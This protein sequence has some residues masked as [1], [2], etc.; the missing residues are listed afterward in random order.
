MKFR[1]SEKSVR[2]IVN[3]LTT[4]TDCYKISCGNLQ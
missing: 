3:V 1:N 2:N 4:S